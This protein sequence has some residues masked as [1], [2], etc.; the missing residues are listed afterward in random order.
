MKILIRK[1]GEARWQAPTVHEYKDERA[2]Q[3][4]LE[5]SPDIWPG[6]TGAA[7]A[8]VSEFYLPQVGSIDLVG[9]DTEG[10]ITLVECKLQ[11][12]P[13][14]RRHVVG[15]IFAYAAGISK[16]TFDEFD[17]SFASRARSSLIDKIASLA[18]GDLNREGFRST[19]SSNLADGRFRLVI[20]VDSITEELKDMVEFIN[21]HT[22]SDVEV[23]AL[24]LGYVASENVEILIPEVYGEESSRARPAAR[25]RSWTDDEL[26]K[27]LDERCKPEAA[28]AF[29]QF[30]DFSKERASNLYWGEGS[31]YPSVTVWF[32]IGDQ[33]VATW[34]CYAYQAGP[35]L[36]VNF[37]WLR[38][39]VDIGRLRTLADQLRAIPGA[40]KSM[41]GLEEADFR[42]RPSF[43]LDAILAQPGAV[44]R[45]RAAIA[46]LIS[47]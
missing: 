3:T 38:R 15:Q 41:V 42:K 24:E 1:S 34:S 33:D 31:N 10:N 35:K 25:G 5:H 13:E 11:A 29:R 4:L 26:F 21:K 32:K 23:L 16:M 6:S 46:G 39:R 7:S 12:N 43:L 19:V 14:V 47:S 40:D 44:E 37:E 45:F 30:F 22:I 28:A 8:V 18:V 20:A 36:E 9:I 27:A 2:L 17:R